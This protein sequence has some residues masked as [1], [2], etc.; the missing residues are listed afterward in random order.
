M[1]CLRAKTCIVIDNHQRNTII[2]KSKS[3]NKTSL[4]TL[5]YIEMQLD[6][7]VNLSKHFLSHDSVRLAKCYYCRSI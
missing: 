3:D 5:V 1:F 4:G 7:K 2:A 6:L